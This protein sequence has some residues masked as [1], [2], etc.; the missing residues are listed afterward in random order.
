MAR[1]MSTGADVLDADRRLLSRLAGASSARVS[2][3]SPSVRGGS[4]CKA[5]TM[6]TNGRRIATFSFRNKEPHEIARMSLD[7]VENV[8]RDLTKQA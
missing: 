3:W 7:S 4:S 8:L 5:Q 1:L 2:G 6:R